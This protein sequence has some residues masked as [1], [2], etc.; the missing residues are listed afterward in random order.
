[1]G[2]VAGPNESMRCIS[3]YEAFKCW[4]VSVP[5]GLGGGQI[6]FNDSDYGGSLQSLQEAR[7]FRDE[8]FEAVGLPLM[9]RVSITA[10]RRERGETLAIYD[11]EDRRGGRVVRGIWMETVSGKPRQRAVQ[12][13][14]GKHGEERARAEVERLVREGI[15]RES[16]RIEFAERNGTL[17]MGDG[18]VGSRRN[19]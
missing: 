4:R 9:A 16:S 15:E 19:R 8:K 13:S 14:C 5:K 3:R 11:I 17:A 2:A 7:Y 6:Y 1:M 10:A 18:S 12:R